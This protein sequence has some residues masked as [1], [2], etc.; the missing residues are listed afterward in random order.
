MTSPASSPASSPAAAIQSQSSIEVGEISPPARS[1]VLQV[2]NLK[3]N[4]KDQ[5]DQGMSSSE[6]PQSQSSNVSEQQ[7]VDLIQQQQLEDNHN[8]SHTSSNTTTSSSPSSASLQGVVE[9]QEAASASAS[10]AAAVD[11]AS[12]NDIL[13]ESQNQNSVVTKEEVVTTNNNENEN[14]NNQDHHQSSPEPQNNNE[15]EKMEEP[16]EVLAAAKG[17]PK[18]KRAKRQML[19][20]NRRKMQEE[21]E[22]NDNNNDVVGGILAVVN[23]PNPSSSSHGNNP[24]SSSKVITMNVIMKT[25]TAEELQAES[26]VI[27]DVNDNDIL[28][29]SRKC[30][31][32]PGNKVYRDIVRKYQP[33]LETIRDRAIIANMVVDHI[34][35]E[36][37]GRFLKVDSTNQWHVVPR[38]DVITKITK[39]LVE[40]R[41][42]PIG[43]PA[44]PKSV[45]TS[46][47]L[48]SI[49]QSIAGQDN[50][51][52][53]STTTTT[54]RP[55]RKSSIKKVKEEQ[56]DD[57]PME[58]KIAKKRKKTESNVDA[59]G[60]QKHPPIKKIKRTLY[61]SNKE[62]IENQK[63]EEYTYKDD[64][65]EFYVEETAHIYH[66]PPFPSE[67]TNG[68]TIEDLRPVPPPLPLP[69]FPKTNYCQWSFDE[70]SRVLIAD[71]TPSEGEDGKQQHQ[72]VMTTEDSKFLFEMYERDDITV[73]SRGLLNLFKVDPS[74]W[75]LDYVNRC[76]G[77]EFYHKFRRFDRVVD[78]K[79]MEVYNEMDTLYSMRFEDFVQY[80][81]LRKTY[82]KE[83]QN[84]NFKEEPV[85]S[86]EDHVGK[87]HSLGVWTSALYMIDVDIMRLMPL[88]NEN[89]L[90]SF[91]LSSV[92]PGG[93]H[94]MM[95]SVSYI[96]RKQTIRYYNIF[97][98]LIVKVMMYTFFACI[99]FF[100]LQM[101]FCYYCT[102]IGNT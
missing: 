29:G 27:D 47:M 19:P 8:S 73:I 37:G 87:T 53:S 10:G 91:E 90:E 14:E 18:M 69:I 46:T 36:I 82:L 65:N 66:N 23:K 54:K 51:I 33:Q 12:K 80:C 20:L 30:N 5:Q 77:R 11:V 28:M 92:L 16:S 75:S 42:P 35:N 39:A 83:R 40:L 101:I 99:S 61:N 6:S 88:L 21:K 56:V 94:C 89:F 13:K 93:S 43:G 48:E 85:F 64:P 44:V 15:D 98:F 62:Q 58:K 3:K 70:K 57:E 68:V 60:K 49:G 79:G 26:I 17:K 76:V 102:I 63:F 81:D 9:S 97:I 74:L 72:F 67:L 31:K 84:N 4:L 86:F 71:F 25:P 2:F 100:N 34:H 55:K 1:S 59:G 32:H 50:I 38:L 22:A 24:H 52:I 95:N 7:E 45:P 78:E 41:N 96:L